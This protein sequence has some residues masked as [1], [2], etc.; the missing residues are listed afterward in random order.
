MR[1]K[2]HAYYCL[3]VVSAAILASCAADDPTSVDRPPVVRYFYPEDQNFDAF[4]G[5]TVSFRIVAVDPDETTLKQRF[6]LNDSLV[7]SLDS[8]NYV[9]AGEGVVSIKCVVSDGVNDARILWEVTQYDPVNYPPKIFAFTPIEANPVMV[10]GNELEFGIEANDPEEVPLTYYFTVNDSLVTEE[11]DF[12]YRP[13]SVGYK[14]VEGV[15][16]DG[17]Y[18]ATHSWNLRVT[19][20]PDTI[21]PAVVPLTL[22]ATGDEPGEIIIEWTAVGADGMQGIASNYLVRTLPSPMLDEISWSWGSGRPDVPAPVAPGEPMRIVINGLI[23]ARFSHIAVRAVDDFGN[24]SPLGESPGVYTRG[25][26]I[27]GKVMDAVTGAPLADQYVELAHFRTST[28]AGGEFEFIELPP[29]DNPLIVSDDNQPGTIGSYYDY[30][31]VYEVNHLDYIVVAMI[32]D[33]P[34]VTNRYTDF[35][36]FFIGMTEHLGLPFPRHQRRFEAP[37]DVYANPFVNL[38]LDYQ[39]VIHQAVSDLNPYLGFDAFR[40]ADDIPEV[41][42]QCVYLEELMYDN[43]GIRVWSDDWYP[44]QGVIEFRVVWDAA[45]QLP[46][47]RVIRHELGH[48]LGLNHSEDQGHLMVGGI[49]PQVDNFSSDEINIIKTRFNIPRGVPLATYVR[50]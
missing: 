3:F 6:S 26:K 4:V 28:D 9:V 39:A 24:L 23:P 48:V 18:F 1:L 14:V 29:L 7:S 50:E 2:R 16:T 20:V 12:K 13:A 33:I 19:P 10:I 44:V 21:P 25:M 22:V 15:V 35:L 49:A 47:E 41:G 30:H 43:Y 8:W 38:G 40:V 37:I 32:P 34:L 46:F 45:H 11:A 5:D 17:E 27:A 42:V 31:L 36:T